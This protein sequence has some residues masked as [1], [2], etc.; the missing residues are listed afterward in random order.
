MTTKAKAATDDVVVHEGADILRVDRFLVEAARDIA[1]GQ[2]VEEALEFVTAMIRLR[3]ESFAGGSAVEPST[4]VRD[5]EMQWRAVV[6]H[7]SVPERMP[8]EV[9]LRR[10][11]AEEF[12]AA[13]RERALRLGEARA[14]G[15]PDRH[16]DE[17]RREVAGWRTDAA[18]VFAI[19]DLD[20]AAGGV[21]PGEIC[22]LCGAQGTMKTSLALSGVEAF[23]AARKGRV[24]FLSLDMSP[25]RIQGRRLIRRLGC[26]ER[27]LFEH[28]RAGTPEL[29]SAVEDVRRQNGEAFELLGNAPAARWTM[30][31]LEEHIRYRNVPDL[32]VVD[33]LTLLRPVRISDL[34]CVNEAMPRLLG[35]AQE[36]GIR[37]VLLSQMSRAAK[38]DQ[39]AGIAAGTGK[40]GGIVEELADVQI[41]LVKDSRSEEE[42]AADLPPRIVATVT[43]TRRGMA[44][45]S[46]DLEYLAESM[47]FTGVARRVSRAKPMKPMFAGWMG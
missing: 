44:G 3:V 25:G 28:I 7:L 5:S 35:L 18:F 41:D 19:P 13:N 14:E 11:V 20:Q 29:K 17:F 42:T 24:L 30:D 2:N 31:R 46:F 32:L 47:S 36:F 1:D 4:L 15:D 21:L 39:A 27:V 38:R 8:S 23:L 34:E 10:M 9:R 12:A 37:T 40:G 43:K 33:F 16:L 45:R 6:E 22:V 26:G